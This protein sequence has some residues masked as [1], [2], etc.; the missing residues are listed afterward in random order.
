MFSKKKITLAYAVEKCPKCSMLKKRKFAEGD[1]LF[2]ESSKC[3]SCGEST[4]I[5][6]I[7][8]ETLEQ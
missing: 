7:F 6:K 3:N 2:S 1:V 4:M 5:E 8:G